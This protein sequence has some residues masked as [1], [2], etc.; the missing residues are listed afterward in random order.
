MLSLALEEHH[1]CTQVSDDVEQWAPFVRFAPPGHFYSPIPRMGD[2]E[3][4]AD[5]IWTFPESIPGI[6]HRPDE[7]RDMIA[8]IAEVLGGDDLPDHAAADRRYYAI[9]PASGSATPRC[10]T[11]C[12]GCTGPGRSSRS[13]RATRRR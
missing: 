9:N 1:V 12:S 10:S 6:D 5:R 4:D 13:G 8:R 11:G 7:Q 2:I 3:A